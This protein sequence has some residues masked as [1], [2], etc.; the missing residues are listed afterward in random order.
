M[1][2]VT[3]DPVLAVDHSALGVFMVSGVAPHNGEGAGLAEQ[4]NTVVAF[5]TMEFHLVTQGC[6]CLY[7]K[8]IVA[9]LGFL[10]G[11]NLRAVLTNHLFKLV[12]SGPEPIDI[13]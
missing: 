3:V 12:Q 8:F 13:K 7:G 9:D 1:Q 11:N 6:Y 2:A 4:S 5:L 10:Q